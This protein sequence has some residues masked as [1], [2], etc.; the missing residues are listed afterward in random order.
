MRSYPF[1]IVNLMTSKDGTALPRL[2][3]AIWLHCKCGHIS[4]PDEY[5]GLRPWKIGQ[6]QGT[7][8]ARAPE[9][10]KLAPLGEGSL[11][12]VEQKC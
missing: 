4:K 1:L 10:I 9:D 6:S 7:T 3:I 8:V 2:C 12:S 11:D 5:K